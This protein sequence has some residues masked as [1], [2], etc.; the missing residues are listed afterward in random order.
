MKR[1]CLCHLVPLTSRLLPA[2]I[3]VPALNH[4]E[5]EGLLIIVVQPPRSQAS[6]LR[7]VPE[8]YVTHAYEQKI[9][10]PVNMPNTQAHDLSNTS[11]S[12]A[13]LSSG[14]NGV[15]PSLS[16]GGDANGDASVEATTRSSE[17]RPTA[18]P[19]VAFDAEYS[20]EI[21]EYFARRYQDVKAELDRLKVC[22]YALLH[23]R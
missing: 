3:A 9:Q 11:T 15:A 23:R 21:V 22:I 14:P 6:G 2:A 18:R 7:P 12:T 1:R 8:L 4:I 5:A 20:P 17:A 13:G 16:S 10:S 19:T